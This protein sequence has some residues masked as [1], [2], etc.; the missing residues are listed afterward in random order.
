MAAIIWYVRVFHTPLWQI[1]HIFIRH[2]NYAR[3][4]VYSHT[5]QMNGVG[6]M[7]RHSTE[8]EKILPLV[9]Q[10][11]T[12]NTKN[13]AN[14]KYCTHMR[15]FFTKNIFHTKEW[16]RGRNKEPRSQMRI[17]SIAG[18]LQPLIEQIALKSI[19]DSWVLLTIKKEIF[20]LCSRIFLDSVLTLI[21]VVV[22]E[23]FHFSSNSMPE[24]EK[25]I[26]LPHTNRPWMI[27]LF[28]RFVS[29]RIT[30]NVSR[31]NFISNG[32]CSEAFVFVFGGS[33]GSDNGN[34]QIQ[35]D[36]LE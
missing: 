14:W 3:A 20:P 8:K 28:F 19:R 24:F 32:K 6:F 17:L 23:I 33:I 18:N 1:F 22:V 26:S 27:L 31:W 4:C 30:C 12:A 13:N 15:I 16:R 36:A 29:C 5:N 10:P 21:L 34:R 11:T 2:T 7:P 25:L 35:C 9:P